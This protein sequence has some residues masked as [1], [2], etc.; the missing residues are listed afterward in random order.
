M[1]LKTFKD[2]KH[3]LLYCTFFYNQ[4]DKIDNHE[5]I[6]VLKE[7]VVTTLNSNNFRHLEIPNHSYH[8]FM[9]LYNPN[10]YMNH[11]NMLYPDKD[12]LSYIE[13]L[14]HISEL[15]AI[16]KEYLSGLD[17]KLKGYENKFDYLETY[18]KQHYDFE[19]ETNS[20]SLTRNW[21]ASGKCIPI[22]NETLIFVGWLPK[23]LN[24]M[25]IIH[26]LTHSFINT[27]NLP[28]SEKI[29]E[30]RLMCP[31]YIKNSYGMTQSFAEDALIRALV[32]Y[33]DKLEGGTFGFTFNRMDT[34]MQLPALFLEKL[35]KDG[36]VKLTKDYINS[37]SL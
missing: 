24:S 13:E 7:K 29:E 23:G 36:L 14:G 6:D 9:G 28:I 11:G 33:F 3:F 19:P 10:G 17:E 8:Y 26:E 22:S 32:V 15:E 16:Y 27:C 31:D 34:D 12:F 25:Q 35:E 1:E 21:D 5:I 30:I 37:F 18:F 20:F 2:K 4:G